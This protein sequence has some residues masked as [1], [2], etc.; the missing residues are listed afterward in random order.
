MNCSV[1]SHIC[2]VYGSLRKLP[3]RCVSTRTQPDVYKLVKATSTRQRSYEFVPLI[4]SW[5]SVTFV[6]TTGSN[7]R[8]YRRYLLKVLY[9][10]YT[11]RVTVTVRGF[12]HVCYNHVTLDNQGIYSHNATL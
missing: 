9:I 8:R 5:H 10:Q 4:I 3:N 6:L 11:L 2:L 7:S 1:K 12:S